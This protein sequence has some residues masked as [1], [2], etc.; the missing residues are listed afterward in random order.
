MKGL[1][2]GYYRIGIRS[3]S[4]NQML[5]RALKRIENKEP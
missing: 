1:C 3:H 2:E 4:E 5:V